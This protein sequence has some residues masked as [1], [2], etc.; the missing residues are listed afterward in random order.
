MRE[1]LRQHG[2]ARRRSGRRGSRSSGDDLVGLVGRHPPATRAARHD[3]A[4]GRRPRRATTRARADL[5][6]PRVALD[7]RGARRSRPPLTRH[8]A[9]QRRRPWSGGRRSRRAPAARRRC[10]GGT[11]RSARRPAR[12][13]GSAARGARR[14]GTPPGAGRRRSCRCRARPARRRSWRA[15]RERCRPARAGWSRRCRAS[16]RLRGRSISASRISLC[17]VG[18]AS[19]RGAAAV[20]RCL[21]LVRRQRRRAGS[22]TGGAAARPSA[23]SG[24]PGRTA[25]RSAPASRRRAGRRPRR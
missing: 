11:R 24:W 7:P 13:A 10:S 19:L 23:R 8:A 2:R 20:A 17:T 6:H 25:A 9:D 4:L 22:R 3:E 15:R 16:G 14:A 18:S 12:P 21:V 5:G 1:P